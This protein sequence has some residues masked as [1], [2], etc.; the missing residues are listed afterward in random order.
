MEEQDHELSQGFLQA[1]MA[2]Y[3]GQTQELFNDPIGGGYDVQL[4]RQLQ[5]KWTMH[6][7]DHP[8]HIR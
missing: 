3:N 4:R 7:E 8:K 5:D 6:W 2:F 1:A